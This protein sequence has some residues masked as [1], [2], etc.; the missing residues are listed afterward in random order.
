MTKVPEVKQCCAVEV[1]VTAIDSLKV[2][3]KYKDKTFS[4]PKNEFLRTSW[5]KYDSF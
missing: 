2:T 4:K 1:E 3:F 5:R